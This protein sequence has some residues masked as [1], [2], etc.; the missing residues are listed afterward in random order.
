[1]VDRDRRVIAVFDFDGTITI[2]DSLLPFCR[3]AAGSFFCFAARLLT[4]VPTLVL[5]SLGIIRNDRAKETIVRCFL[6]D[7]NFSALDAI[8]S[9]FVKTRLKILL[10][11]QALARIAWHRENN[12][13]IVLLSASLEVYL[14]HWASLMDIPHLLAT[15]L[16]FK[17]D[18]PSGRLKGLNCHGPEKVER[19]R[20]LFGIFEHHELHV[21][22]DSSSDLPLMGYA[23]FPYWR[24]FDRFHGIRQQ[25]FKLSVFLKAL[26]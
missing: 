24:F 23:N 12:H 2:A 11:D 7:K 14:C 8:A 20:A 13:E 25:L 21:Y 15:G 22:G 5:F 19:L 1:M 16:D 4:C 3:H 17:G 6:A 26:I 9:D 18:R 10:N